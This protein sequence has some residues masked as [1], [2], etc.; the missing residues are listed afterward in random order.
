[1]SDTALTDQ[2]ALVVGGAGFIGSHL[3]DALLPE[4][5]VRVF[6]DLSTGKRGNVNEE[7]DLVEADVRNER[8]L[9]EAVEGVDVIF[10]QAGVVSVEQ[11]IEEPEQS[12]DVNVG[13]TL[14]LLEEAREADARVVL[15]SS[16][17]IYGSPSSVPIPETASKTPMS[18]YGLQKLTLDHYARLYHDLYGVETVPLRY[19]N[20]Y[21][22]RQSGGDYSGVISIFRRQ[23]ERGE[24]ITVEGSG[25]QT[26]DFVHVSDVV[27]ANLLAAT[28]D[29]VGEAYNVGTGTSVSVNELAETMRRVTESSSDIVHTEPRP[30]DIQKS[31]ADISLARA[32]LGYEPSVSLA[33]GLADLVGQSDPGRDS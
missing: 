24:P 7:A 12:N 9:A 17:A 22:P 14:S 2:R 11:S 10:H 26:R 18:P 6:D 21:G 16:C 27:R 4:N 13:A 23:A 32:K 15:A 19:F 29:H 30:G 33:E 1:M 5:E 28:T 20:A 25:E 8:A 3:V 31:E